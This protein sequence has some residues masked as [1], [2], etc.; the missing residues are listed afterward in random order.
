MTIHSLLFRFQRPNT[1]HYVLTM[2]HTI[3]QGHHYYM[4][5]TIQASTHEIVHSFV[6][7]HTVTNQLHYDTRAL[8]RRLLCGWIDW[9]VRGQELEGN[10]NM[11]VQI[12]VLKSILRYEETGPCSGRHKHRRTPRSYFCRQYHRIRDCPRSSHIPEHQRQPG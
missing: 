8:L 11:N 5:S 9:Y 12:T 4:T 2:E 10:K 3:T 6:R 7:R 1:L